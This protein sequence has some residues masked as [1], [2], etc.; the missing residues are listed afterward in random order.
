MSLGKLLEKNP[1]FTSGYMKK[2]PIFPCGP[3]KKM[4]G[5]GS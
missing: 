3:L 1:Y 4:L 2:T 5:I